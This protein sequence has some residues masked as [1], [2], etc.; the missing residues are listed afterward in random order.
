LKTRTLGSMAITITTRHGVGFLLTKFQTTERVSKC[1]NEEKIVLKEILTMVH[2]ENE[3][4]K[5]NK[6]ID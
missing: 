2:E 4:C 6:I 1:L 5:T 3:C